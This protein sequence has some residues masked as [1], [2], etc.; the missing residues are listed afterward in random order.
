MDY[1]K[2]FEESRKQILD[3]AEKYSQ[4]DIQDRKKELERQWKP[5]KDEHDLLTSA[6]NELELRK[7]YGS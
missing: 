4:S 1:D 5:L 2:Y 7:I 3:L 6:W